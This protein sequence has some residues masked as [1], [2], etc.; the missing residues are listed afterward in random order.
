MNR[1]NRRTS[2]KKSAGGTLIGLFV[3]LV[4]GVVA[5]ALVVWYIQRTPPPFSNKTPATLPQSQDSAPVVLPSKPGDP[6]PERRFDFYEILSGKNDPA[7]EG[8][9]TAPANTTET[10]TPAKPPVE[11]KAK[12]EVASSTVYLQ[13]GSFQNAADA[14]NQK[15]KLAMMGLEA[16]VQQAMLQEKVWYRVRLGPFKSEEANAMRA[17]LAKNSINAT[18]VK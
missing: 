1:H 9:S 15:A 2:S 16:S 17:E 7:P 18:V 3:G 6:V 4:I 10:A 14:D 11:D 13:T 12:T 5:A 8:A